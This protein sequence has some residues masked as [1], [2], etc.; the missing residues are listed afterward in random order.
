MSPR[1]R[2][3]APT[4]QARARAAEIVDRLDAS[5]PEARI[6]L[7][8]QDDLQLLVSVILSA[9]STD[10]GVNKATPA[11]FARYPDAAAYAAAQPEE[12][13]PY[14]RSL[15]LFRNKAK[16]IVAAMD[17]IAREHGG[18]VPRTRE[19]LEAL[20]GVG[21]KTAGV[22]LVHLGA[23]EAFPVDTHVGRV[24]RRLGLTREQDPDRVERDLMALLPEAR[25]GRGHQ[26][27]VWHGRRTCAARAPACSRCVVADLCPKRGVPAAIRR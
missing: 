19:G 18:R 5:M 22:V 2:P 15:G 8:F 25:W 11:L 17:A 12:L 23:A 10:A 7:A 13:W 27:F 24:S 9:Q 20:P 14:I 21:R 16:A 4:A 1:P 3:R 6:A 26:L